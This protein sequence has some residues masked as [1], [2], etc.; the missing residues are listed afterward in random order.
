MSEGKGVWVEGGRMIRDLESQAEEFE[1]E[2]FQT[3]NGTA[4]LFCS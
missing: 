3:Q 4:V 1:C 2:D